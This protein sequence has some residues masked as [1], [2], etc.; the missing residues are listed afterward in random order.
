M[1]FLIAPGSN[2]PSHLTKA[3]ALR[4]TL[5]A[6]GHE[7]LLALSAAHAARIH[8][9]NGNIHILPDIQES[10]NAAM[11]TVE[12][13]RNGERLKKC[14]LQEAELIRT[15]RPDRV[16][17]IFRFTTKAAAA[18]HCVPYDSLACGCLM[19]SATTALGYGPE[20]PGAKTQGDFM[21]GFFRYGGAKM[22]KALHGLGLRQVMEV[23]DLRQMLEGDRTFLWDFDAFCPL[24][25]DP[26]RRHTGPLFWEPSAVQATPP[27][28]VNG[29]APKALVSFGTCI[30]SARAL[31]R[32]VSAL[33]RLGFHVVIAAGGQSH[34][35]DGLPADAR[36]TSYAFTSLQPLLPH[37]DLL[38]CHGGQMTLFEA[39]RHSVPA[40]VFPLQPE[41]AHNGFCAERLGVGSRLA[42]SQPFLGNPEIYVEGLERLSETNLEDRISGFLAQ[43]SLRDNLAKAQREVLSHNAL[44]TLAVELA[45]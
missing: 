13:F 20:E 36:V 7:V 26:A 6:E 38:V 16:V 39:F 40:L 37:V 3:L 30:G 4:E 22:A 9:R 17:G 33:L 28:P 43:P 23:N 19:P 25:P 5:G 41:Q 21:S 12:W 14:I 42:P 10:D 27:L 8:Q 15:L 44:E 34:L 35:L 32:V 2:S 18:L 11:P 29:G 1:R 31:R 45:R 24:P